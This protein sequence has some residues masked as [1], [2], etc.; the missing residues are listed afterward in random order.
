MEITNFTIS[1]MMGRVSMLLIALCMFSFVDEVSAQGGATCATAQAVTAGTHTAGMLAGGGAS[2]NCVTGATSAAWYSFTPTAAGTIDITSENDPNLIDTRLSFY[3][4]TCA[5][6]NCIDF[7]DDDGAGLT[8]LLTGL[9]VCPGTTYYIEWDDR[10]DDTSFTWD[11]TFN[12]STAGPDNSTCLLYTSP[13]PRDRTRS[14]MP[15][16]A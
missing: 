4:G 16:S 5:A 13:S 3:D 6:L 10:W 14:R 2:N 8:S 9:D 12:A 15:S 7:D 1:K 11:L